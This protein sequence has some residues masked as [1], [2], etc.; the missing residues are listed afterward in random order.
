MPVAAGARRA[1]TAAAE[2]PERS[3]GDGG[4][5]PGILH[6]AEVRGLVR[7]AHRELVHVG[8]AERDHAGGLR[9]SLDHVRV[10]RA[11]EVGSI[12][13]P[14]VVSQPRV[15]K[16]S[17]CAT[18][19]RSAALASPRAMRAS[20]A[21]ACARLSS[22]VDRDEG[23]QPVEPLDALEEQ[24]GQLDAGDLL[25][26]K[27]AAELGDRFVRT[28]GASYSMTFGTRYRPS[29]RAGALRMSRFAPGRARR[30]RPRAGAGCRLSDATSAR[31]RWCRP[32]ASA[33][34]G[35]RCRSAGRAPAR[36][37]LGDLEAREL[38]DALDVA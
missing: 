32:P 38:G 23:V 28:P 15:T 11:D 19:S 3:A 33:R 30:P 29:W 27:R 25:A 20:A 8:L 6:R 37:L 10:E 17:L 14:Q 34:S 1:A 7:R 31:C 2:P 4:R 21:R 35:R 18:G 13:E 16:M 36:L 24:P 5:V 12:F 26:G 9:D 22:G